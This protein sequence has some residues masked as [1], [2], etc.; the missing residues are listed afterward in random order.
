MFTV[1][2]TSSQ[3]INSLLTLTL[4]FVLVFSSV[5]VTS[6]AHALTNPRLQY[7]T[8]DTVTTDN[9]VK[10]QFTIVNG[11]TS[12]ALSSLKIRYYFSENTAQTINAFCDYAAVNCANITT[13]IVSIPAVAGA[14]HYLEVGFTAG[15]GSLAPNASSGEI[16]IRL[17]KADWSNFNESND[18]SF[19][20]TKLAFADWNK[21]AIYNSGI[22]AWGITPGNDPTAVPTLGATATLI[23]T[24]VPTT[25]PTTGPTIAPTTVNPATVRIEAGGL[26]NHTDPNGNTWLADT[27]FTAGAGGVADRG[28]IAIA[29]TTTPRIYQTERWGM[30]GFAYNVANGSYQVNL[31]FAETYFT[32]AGLRVFSVNVEGTAVNNIDVFTQAGGANKALVKTVT[33]TVADGQL[34]IT[35]AATVNNAEINGIE[36]IPSGIIPATP[37]PTVAPTTVPTTVPTIAPTTIPTLAPT[38]VPTTIPTLVPTVVPPTTVPGAWVHPGTLDNKANLDYAKAQLA[39]GAQPYAFEFQTMLNNERLA[40]APTVWITIDANSGQ[41]DAARDQA[42]AAYGNALAWYLT[43]QNSYAQ[44]AIADLNAFAGLQSITATN[45]QNKLVAGWIGSLL[46]PAADIMLTYPG[47]APADVA[48]LRAMFKRAFYPQLNTASSWNGNVDL[49]QTSAMMAIAVFNEDKAE[50]DLGV[51]RLAARMPAYFYLTTDP[52]PNAAT[53][54]NPTKW[55]N[56][57]TQESCRDNGHHSQFA[58][59]GATGAME[60]AWNQGVD[61]YSIYQARIVPAMELMALQLTSGSMQ[62]TCGNNASSA[63]VYDTWEIGYNHYHNISGVSMPNTLNMILTKV[64]L[65]QSNGGSWNIFYESLTHAK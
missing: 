61:L 58:L 47:W 21:A 40:A 62:G 49:H 9:Q 11:D 55:V 39:L 30:T 36:I 34:N 25:I 17:A 2:R 29:N 1:R 33:V 56:G 7:R 3:I 22:L 37:V 8:G 51:S 59:S 19:D 18:Y 52:Q 57:L 5:V 28:N 48:N 45:D 64:R 43:G 23:P 4:L 41:A 16:Q 24:T 26:A 60:T 38:L 42:R 32:A 65:Y 53:W 15:A 63:D 6:Q 35:F 20:A 31:H 10:P 14:D 46:A 54:F 50:F 12:V 44:Q 13:T 27:G